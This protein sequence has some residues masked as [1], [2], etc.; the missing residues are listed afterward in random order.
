MSFH[1]NDLGKNLDTLTSKYDNTILLVDFNT[2]PTD[3]TLSY[4]C[5]VY[6]LKNLIKDMT[7]VK[8]P[9]KASCIYLRITN[10]QKGFNIIKLLKQVYLICT[11][12]VSQQ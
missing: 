7:Y 1:L 2:E 5:E 11:K 4:F 12:R 3:T 10:R 8:N 6:N 9:N